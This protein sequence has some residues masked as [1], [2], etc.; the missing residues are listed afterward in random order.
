MPS[1]F[2]LRVTV[3]VLKVTR[4]SPRGWSCT[5][6]WI[7][8]VDP[9][10]QEVFTTSLVMCNQTLHQPLSQRFLQHRFW[11]DKLDVTHTGISPY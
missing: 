9:Q 3:C 11:P 2:P 8:P 1:C 6:Y 5:R 7:L 4:N 10:K